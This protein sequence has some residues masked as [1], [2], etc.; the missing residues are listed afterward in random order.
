[1]KRQ[2]RDELQAECARLRTE[3]TVLLHAVNILQRRCAPNARETVKEK[4]GD[5][6]VYEAY[7][8]TAAHG[9][10]LLVTFHYPGQRPLTSAYYLE[11]YWHDIQCPTHRTEH[12]CAVERLQSKARALQLAM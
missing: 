11:S 10:I 3:N 1:M 4:D 5:R 8:V 9:G 6:Y 7:C 12:R 2:T